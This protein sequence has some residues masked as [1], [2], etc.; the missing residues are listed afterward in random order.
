MSRLLDWFMQSLQFSSRTFPV[1]A[2]DYV[3]C[4]INESMSL[5]SI[6][7]GAKHYF[8]CVLAN[9]KKMVAIDVKKTN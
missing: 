7:E 1:V 6:S 5:S 4:R 2:A 9:L 3:S 8:V